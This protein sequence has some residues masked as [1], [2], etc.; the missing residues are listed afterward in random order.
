METNNVGISC[1]TPREVQQNVL[2][3]TTSSYKNT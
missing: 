2:K 1:D 3:I